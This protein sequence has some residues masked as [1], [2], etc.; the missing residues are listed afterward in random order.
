MSRKFD[1][2][3]PLESTTY[4]EARARDGAK[5]APTRAKADEANF[6]MDASL[7]H[8]CASFTAASKRPGF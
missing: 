8:A 6:N 5:N 3:P 4:V 2:A 7:L 1:P